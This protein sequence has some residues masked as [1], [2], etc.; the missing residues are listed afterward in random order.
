MKNRCAAM[1]RFMLRLC[2][3]AALWLPAAV[4]QAQPDEEYQEDYEGYGIKI[5]MDEAVGK[6]AQYLQEGDAHFQ[7]R[8]WTDAMAAYDRALFLDPSSHLAYAA[9]ANLFYSLGAARQKK[10]QM[11]V[12]FEQAQRDLEAA[13][14]DYTAALSIDPQSSENGRYYRGRAAAYQALGDY[15]SALSDFNLAIASTVPTYSLYDQRALIYMELEE[16]DLALQ[17]LYQALI[18]N[19]SDSHNGYYRGLVFL[20]QGKYEE[21]LARFEEV[22]QP[23]GGFADAWLQKGIVYERLGRPLDALYAYQNFLR[24]DIEGSQEKLAFAQERVADLH[25]HEPLLKAA[26][27]P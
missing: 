1:R 21:A 27:H 20:R 8:R 26:M 23:S 14:R 15:A 11:S 7:R 6:A 19:P 5:S 4:S 17:D 9:R 22:T 16:Y 3:A 13:V 2:L 10:A 24:R 25:G 18:L 12:D